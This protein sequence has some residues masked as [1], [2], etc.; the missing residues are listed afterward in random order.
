VTTP[1]IL[2]I[3]QLTE[4]VAAIFLRLGMAATDVQVMAGTVVAA[5]RDGARGHGLQRMR[6]YVSSIEAGWVDPRA[7]PT[8]EQ[9]RPGL[10]AADAANGFAQI[11]LARAKDRLLRMVQKN[12]TAILATRNSHHFAALWPDIEP[13]AEASFIALTMANTRPWMA[14][15]GGRR[16]ALGTNPIA[17]ACPVP[18]ASPL[19]WDQASSIM[20]QGEVLLH[21]ASGKALP[22]GT[23]IDRAGDPTTDPD[24][25]LDGGALL[26]FAGA[27]GASIAFMVEIL[28]AAF[29]GGL[30]GFEDRSAAVP[31]AVTSN[32][33]QFL[34]LIDP[35]TAGA[36]D[37]DGRVAGLIAFI[38]ASGSERLPGDR[39]YAARQQSVLNGI[40]VSPAM[41]AG[42]HRLAGAG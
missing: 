10:L 32:A 7:E 15:W 39:R 25:V 9:R 41:L 28:V 6:G 27:K 1:T 21:R 17:F 40:A 2:S 14:A 30:F 24:A 29:G 31:G 4:L 12:G 18:D 23:G 3:D 36:M 42:L 11:A 35:A 5:E 38:R 26:P 37:F 13:F 19:V 8:F 16:R 33:G 22:G 20:S 34:L